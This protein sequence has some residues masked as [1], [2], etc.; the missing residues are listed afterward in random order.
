MRETERRQPRLS[1]QQQLVSL[2]LASFSTTSSILSLLFP[3][4]HPLHRP[5]PSGVFPVF[6][7]HRRFPPLSLTPHSRQLIRPS[8]PSPLLA[9]LRRS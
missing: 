8:R 3:P 5:I 1:S 2:P 4:H 6:P 7:V 9:S